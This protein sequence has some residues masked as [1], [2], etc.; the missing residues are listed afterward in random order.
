MSADTCRNRPLVQIV[1]LVAVSLGLG[2]LSFILPANARAQGV[3][4]ITKQESVQTNDGSTAQDQLMNQAIKDVSR[5][6]IAGFIGEKRAAE[7][8]DAIDDKIIKN[9]S[10]YILSMS[11]ENLTQNNNTYSMAVQ[12][13]LS[14][15]AL[16]SMLLANGFLYKFSGP[17]KVLPIIK[18]VDRVNARSY[19]WW[20]NP[21]SRDYGDLRSDAILFDRTLKGT[22]L[23]VGFYSLS[24]VASRLRNSIPEPYRNE[25][26]QQIDALFLGEYLKSPV[27]L[28]GQVVFLT[29]PQTLNI[30]QIDIR[31]R[32]LY[33]GTG[34]LLAEI[35]RTYTTDP[36]PFLQVVT[37][38]LNAVIPQICKNLAAQLSD[39]WRRGT[40]GTSVIR[41]KVHG[42]LSP[43]QFED[44]QSAVLLSVHDVKAF[45]ERIIAAHEVTY[46]ADAS[47]SPRQVAQ[48]FQ[49]AGFNQYKVRVTDVS[50]D[51]VSLYVRVL[52]DHAN[53]A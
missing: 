41:V 51:G 35:N 20:Y 1:F 26:L 34:R 38:K 37:D 52:A 19:G 10:R 5:Q 32:A 39:V 33:A 36:G 27:V 49:R 40:F 53:G 14:L 17:P 23:N 15:T 46:D 24:P 12:L 29:P 6:Y 22:L 48:E 9:S 21:A 28:R 11:G 30:T 2:I 8:K 4:N 44:F 31:L 13:T 43:K 47:N 7:L 45:N 18:Y 3:L 16:R 25:N 42:D 50:P